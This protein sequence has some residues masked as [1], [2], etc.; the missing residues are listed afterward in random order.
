MERQ[1]SKRLN[2]AMLSANRQAYSETFIQ[3]QKE[4]L[5]HRI[6]YYYGGLL[7][8]KIENDLSLK[9]SFSQR[10]WTTFTRSA[11]NMLW[12]NI[13]KSFIK[14]HI[15]VVFA[16]FG[17]VGAAVAPI[18]KDLNLPLVVHYHGADAYVSSYINSGESYKYLFQVAS[19]IIVVSDD[20]KRQLL[21]LGAPEERIYLTCYGPREDFF[22]INPR[23]DQKRFLSVGRF[24]DKKAPYFTL[25]AFA[26]VIRNHGEA[27][28]TM[29]GDGPLLFVCKNLVQYLKIEANVE[30]KG[31]LAHNEICN[32]MQNALCFVQHSITAGDGDKEGSPVAIIEA[33]AAGLPVV[34]TKHAGINFTVIHGQTGYLVDEGDVAGMSDYMTKICEDFPLA[35]KLGEAGRNHIR[36]NASMDKYIS[37]INNV[38]LKAYHDKKK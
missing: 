16:Q 21:M 2:L 3:V 10:L 33:S 6:F 9:P 34:A 31:V 36:K 12:I 5:P 1:E 20:M 30:F 18:C 4:Y 29:V 11:K 14:N 35:A 27:T 19:A 7:P 37:E 22:K 17:P 32:L 8:T 24:V 26:S 23:R 15:D 13:K 25:L 38:L 28:L